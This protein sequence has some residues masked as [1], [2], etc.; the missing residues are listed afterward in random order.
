MSRIQANLLLLLTAMIWGST[1]VVQQVGT[2]GLEAMTFTG[3][4]FLLGAL[5]VSP[6]A[7][8]EYRK[9]QKIHHPISTRN[10]LGMILTGVV[11][12]L[13]ATTQQ[14]GIFYTSVANA[15][16]L[17]ALYVPLVPLLAATVLKTPIHWIT[18]P[19]A[20]GCLIGTYIMSGAGTVHLSSGDIWVIGSA[21]FWAIHVLLVGQMATKTQSPLIVAC[22]QFLTVGILGLISGYFFEQPELADFS[23]ATLG[24]LYAGVLS[25]G[26]AFTLQVVAQ[27]FSP[28]ADCA[29]LLS[30][31][32]VFSAL[33][34]FIFLGDVPSSRQFGGALLIL[35]GI[36]AVQLFP[37][38]PPPKEKRTA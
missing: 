23:G 17:T 36:L 2:G 6:L 33:F 11:L 8:I 35:A 31:E 37:L 16:F 29:I 5:V 26:I 4:R 1:F 34:A 21:F 13:A 18:W 32:T 12:F 19:A 24:I 10:L 38:L 25:A 30:G 9:K 14:Q 3:A 7:F 20:C 27:R 15:G 28:A 22:L